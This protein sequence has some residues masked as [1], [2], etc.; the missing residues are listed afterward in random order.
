MIIYEF[1]VLSYS[2]WYSRWSGKKIGWI[3][4][5]VVYSFIKIQEKFLKMIKKLKQ[6]KP[7]DSNEIIFGVFKLFLIIFT[8]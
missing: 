5:S 3:I 4:L 7:L 8:H 6:Q 1:Q 2:H